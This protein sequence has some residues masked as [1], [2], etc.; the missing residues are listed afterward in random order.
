MCEYIVQKDLLKVVK[1]HNFRREGEK[2]EMLKRR[3]VSIFRLAVKA[4]LPLQQN[5]CKRA[6][7]RET[8]GEVYMT[9]HTNRRK[10]FRKRQ[11]APNQIPVVTP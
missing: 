7:E 10:T 9:L 2:Q 4:M 5:S 8:E 6:V 11:H 3:G 1:E